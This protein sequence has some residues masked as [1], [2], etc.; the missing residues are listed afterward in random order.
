MSYQTN[1]IN[2]ASSLVN[3]FLIA[4]GLKLLLPVLLHLF[5]ISML[6]CHSTPALRK[7][8]LILNYLVSD[9]EFKGW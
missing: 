2:E 7:N 6:A 5:V 1:I 9:D 8:R 4:I 3:C